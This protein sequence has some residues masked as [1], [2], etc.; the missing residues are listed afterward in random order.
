MNLMEIEWQSWHCTQIEM[1]EIYAICKRMMKER[2]A[3]ITRVVDKAIDSYI[4][5]LEDEDYYSWNEDAQKQVREAV[6]KHF[7]GK[8]LS[9]FEE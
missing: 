2:K 6:L 1:D 7:G 3:P 4:T 9:V 5:C 8:Q